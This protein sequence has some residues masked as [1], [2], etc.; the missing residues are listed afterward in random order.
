MI[1]VFFEL[2]LR[3][4]NFESTSS[5]VRV[6]IRMGVWVCGRLGVLGVFSVYTCLS[7]PV[8]TRGTTQFTLVTACHDPIPPQPY[9]D[10][11]GFFQD[12]LDLAWTPTSM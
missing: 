8:T 5:G 2:S 3:K 7:F 10:F 11:L 9:G 12:F 6:D 1:L 4:L